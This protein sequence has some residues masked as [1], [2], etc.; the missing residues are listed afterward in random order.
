[1]HKLAKYG[2]GGSGRRLRTVWAAAMS[3][4]LATLVVAGA[5]GAAPHG[6]RLHPVVRGL[7]NP[8]GLAFCPAVSWPWRSVVMRARSVWGLANAL[9]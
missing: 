3:A 5:A 6:A 8:R 7:D 2:S 1:M 4:G 9:G